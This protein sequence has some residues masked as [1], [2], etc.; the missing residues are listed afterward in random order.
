VWHL[1]GE[2]T[3]VEVEV[4]VKG[5]VQVDIKWKPRPGFRATFNR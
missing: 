4:P 3:A 5:T 2:E 1:L